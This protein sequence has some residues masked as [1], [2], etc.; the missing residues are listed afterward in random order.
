MPRLTFERL[1][2]A[3]AGEAVAL[4]QG[5]AGRDEEQRRAGWRRV[6]ESMDR[7]GAKAIA[8]GLTDA[9][10]EAFLADES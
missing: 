4:W 7:L 8:N 6:I 1:R 9:K 2:S 10:L 3:V 5:A